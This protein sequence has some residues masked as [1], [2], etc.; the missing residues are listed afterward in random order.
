MM[1][2]EGPPIGKAQRPTSTFGML[3]QFITGQII[4]EPTPSM[5]L[6]NILLKEI[7]YPKST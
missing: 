6:P 5:L 3:C 7:S 1:E 4:M 2:E